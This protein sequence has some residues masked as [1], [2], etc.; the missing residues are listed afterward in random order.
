[1]N[2]EWIRTEVYHP[3]TVHLPIGLLL[4]ATVVITLQF[5]SRAKAGWQRVVD[6]SLYAGVGF[7]WL[8]VYTGDLADGLVSR[9]L[10]DPTVLKDHENFGFY[11]AYVYSAAAVLQIIV[12][13]I[14][15]LAAKLG[16]LIVVMVWCGAILLFYVG[17]LGASLVY[18]QA[19]GVLVP[20]ENC[21]GF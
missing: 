14:K 8:A 19:A 2:L 15:S 4:L 9:H 5:F 16:L 13:A 1:M 20:T 17:H 3:L 7:I 12:R 21:E 11:T 6:I 10:C 18:E